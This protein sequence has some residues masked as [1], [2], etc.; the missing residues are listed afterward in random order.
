MKKLLCWILCFCVFAG[1]MGVSHAAAAFSDPRVDMNAT[2]SRAD[3]NVRDPFIL[4][5]EDTYFMYATGCAPPGY[6]CYV[7]TDLE[8]WA[9]PVRVWSPPAGSDANG[10]YW[11]PECHYYNGY[12]YIFATYIRRSVGLSTCTILRGDNPLGP[13]T[14]ITPDGMAPAD[15]PWIDSS[16]Y[17]DREGQPWMVYCEEVVVWSQIESIKAVKLLPDLT[18]YA[19][20]PVKLL[21]N[22]DLY[23]GIPHISEGPFL[24]RSE[25]GEL[26]MLWSGYTNNGYVVAQSR[27]ASGDILGPWVHKNWHLYERSYQIEEDAGHGMLFT[28]T[29]GQLYLSVHYPNNWG[30]FGK[31]RAVFVPVRDYGNAVA[32]IADTEPGNFGAFIKDPGVADFLDSIIRSDFFLFRWLGELIYWNVS[33]FVAWYESIFRT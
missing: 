26:L 30:D 19:G 17:V 12:F 5:Y 33:E 24:Y 14:E 28:G 32:V 23:R 6:G 29:D 20:E 4:V 25:T 9:G 2:R 18:G 8:N 11:A 16:F 13:F 22:E 1:A 27:S 15:T 7:S 31:E 10:N 21:G 3:I